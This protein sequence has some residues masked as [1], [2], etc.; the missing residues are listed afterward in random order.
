MRS[1]WCVTGIVFWLCM[2]AAHAVD[3]RVH[4]PQ[5]SASADND[6]FIRVLKLSLAKTGK[7]YRVVER[8]SAIKKGRALRELGQDKAFD[9][10]WAVT[11]IEREREATPV[12]IPVDKGLSGWRIAFVRDADV[13]RFRDVRTLD[14]LRAF[15]AGQGFDWIDTRILKANGLPVTTGGDYVVLARMLALGRFDYFPRSVREIWDEVDLRKQ[16]GVTVEP[17]FVLHYPSALYYF[18]APGNTVLARDIQEGLERAYR[19]GSFDA[20]FN[21]YKRGWFA[22]G[23]FH[24]RAVIELQNP[25]LPPQTPLAE[26]RYWYSP[27]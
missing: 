7:P 10:V 8:R 15:T 2:Q 21:R 26:K 16:E 27:Q 11:S 4:Y 5:A 9:V 3:V 6:Y 12:R 18:V 19:D 22:R 23:G 17:H 14:Q 24:A 20:L 25:D 1:R 13:D